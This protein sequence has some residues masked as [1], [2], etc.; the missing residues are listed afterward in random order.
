[1]K[2]LNQSVSMLMLKEINN[3]L[4]SKGHE[5]IKTDVGCY[6]LP[7][8]KYTTTAYIYKSSVIKENYVIHNKELPDYGT[9]KFKELETFLKKIKDNV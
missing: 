1:M 5:K 2:S 7:G 8:Q 6:R 3:L 9:K 4:V